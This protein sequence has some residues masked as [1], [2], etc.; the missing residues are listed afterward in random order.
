MER[1]VVRHELDGS[2]ATR[3][4][5]LYRRACFVLEA[6]Q[7]A[8]PR[9][10]SL[11]GGNAAEQRANVRRS[12]SSIQAML[13]ARGRAEGYTRDLPAREGYP[14]FLIVCDVGLCSIYMRIS[15]AP[16]NTM[17]RFP[18]REGFLIYFSDLHDS[19]IRD[20]YA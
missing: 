7:G 4:I 9:Q 15:P 18:D 5:D 2:A 8:N 12:A 10:A 17:R 19:A 13:R 16:G 20:A 1:S 6:K 14:P 11:F 3:R